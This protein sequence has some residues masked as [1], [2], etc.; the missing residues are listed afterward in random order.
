M[1]HQ[2]V[3][4]RNGSVSGSGSGRVGGAGLDDEMLAKYAYPS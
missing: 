1:L 4:R 3:C 2:N